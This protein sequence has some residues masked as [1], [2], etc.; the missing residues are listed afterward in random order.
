MTLRHATLGPHRE[1]PGAE[2]GVHDPLQTTR[3]PATRRSATQRNEVLLCGSWRRIFGNDNEIVSHGRGRNCRVLGS[4][5]RGDFVD[6]VGRLYR[7]DYRGDGDS[8][9]RWFA[10]IRSGH[11][12]PLS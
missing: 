6:D 10:G 12:A 2:F 5:L 7:R 8:P 4:S 3:R 9:Y 1:A 11:E